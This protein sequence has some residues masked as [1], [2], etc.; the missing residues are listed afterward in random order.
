L[1]RRI[2]RP[3]K[4]EVVE[5]WRKFLN[6]ELHNLYTS[7]NIIRMIKS[8]ALDVLSMRE[9]MNACRGFLRKPEGKGQ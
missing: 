7:L 3:K 5:A 6:K 9:N 8:R 4:D 2:Y 1:L